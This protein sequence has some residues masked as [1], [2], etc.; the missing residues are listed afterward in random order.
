MTFEQWV[1]SARRGQRFTYHRGFLMEDVDPD[2]NPVG[3]F[4]VAVTAE[5]ARLAYAAGKVALVQERR[6][7][8][9]YNYVAVRL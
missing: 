4:A 5:R 2:V 3:Y 6:G 7:P 8:R 9:N 1:S